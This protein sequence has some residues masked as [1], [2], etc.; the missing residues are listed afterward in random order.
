VDPLVPRPRRPRPVAGLPTVVPSAVARAWIAGLVAAGTLEE[1]GALPV[2]RLAAEGPALAAAVL[3][4]LADDERL[5]ADALRAH[6][7]AVAAA[8]GAGGATHAVRAAEALRHAALDEILAAGRLDPATTA[9]LADRLAHVCAL[10]AAAA[11]GAA[12]EPALTVRRTAAPAA[13]WEAQLAPGVTLLAVEADGIE[14]LLAAVDDGELETL[15]APLAAALAEAV[16]PDGGL[17]PAGPGRWWATTRRDGDALA[18][19]LAS[20]TGPAH[21]GEP[22]TVSV[23]AARCPDDGADAGSLAEH[24]D[25]ALFAARASGR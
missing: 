16:G 2:A 14:R 4:A 19:S 15:M 18:R 9:E 13:S 11:A 3:A 6:A 25:G 5:E 22:L 21:H 23:G 24:A 7:T 17:F 12:G 1:A 8:A 20:V 10:V